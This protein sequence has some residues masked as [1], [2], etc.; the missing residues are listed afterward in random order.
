MPPPRTFAASCALLAPAVAVFSLLAASAATPTLWD[1]TG[2]LRV[3]AGHKQNVLLSAVQPQ[4]SALALVDGELF[5]SHQPAAT[6]EFVGFGSTT[7]TRFVD[8]AENPHE[9]Q[10]FAHGEAR[11]TPLDRLQSTTA[12]EAYHLKQVFDLSINNIERR[13][14]LLAVDGGLASTALR[15][16]LPRRTWFE[17][18]PALQRERFRDHSDD[19]SQHFAVV[20]LGHTLFADRLELSVSGKALRRTYDTRPQYTVAGRPRP[21]TDLAFAQREA[22][23][24]A[25]VRGGEARRWSVATSVLLGTNRDNGSGFF[26]YQHRAVRQEFTWHSAPWSLR[27]VG[28]AGRYDYDVQTHGI[29]INPPFR[30]KEEFL[31]EARLVRDLSSRV[32]A[33]AT[34]T[35]ERSRSNDPLASYRAKTAVAG[36]DLSL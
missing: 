25:R 17:V 28:R 31:V 27:L 11:W 23:A 30:L 7:F 34:F 32:S 33:Y 22:E 35:W 13:T 16:D 24:R 21:G 3:A 15:L 10:A 4:D 6:L 5:F 19:H 8:S 26:D 20:T 2:N 36:L 9:L 12:L 29:G 18:K 1:V 14:A